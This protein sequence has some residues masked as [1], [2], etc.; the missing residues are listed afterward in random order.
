MTHRKDFVR[1]QMLARRT[2]LGIAEWEARSHAIQGMVLGGR[3][4]QRAS[5]VATYCSYKGEVDTRLIFEAG[6]SDGKSF[7]FPSVNRNGRRLSFLPVDEWGKLVPG[8]YDIPAPLP[9]SPGAR[10]L[11]EL[12]L[13]LVPGVAFDLKG[14]RLGY[15][16]GYYDR[17]LGEVAGQVPRLGLAFE[18][19]LV[20]ELPRDP[21]DVTVDFIVTEERVLRLGPWEF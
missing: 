14:Y 4:F 3:P 16:G 2:S 11:N 20:E 5:A 8:A 17:A 1:R 7:Y 15:G 13:V 6:V 21:E 19:Q 10:A 18:L 9:G 12:D